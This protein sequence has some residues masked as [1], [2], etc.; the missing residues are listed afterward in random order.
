M[1]VYASTAGSTIVGVKCEKCSCEYFYELA[2][3]G[4]GRGTAPLGLA[5]GLARDAATQAAEGNLADR[6]ASEAELVPCPRCHWINDDLVRGY[7]RGRYRGLGKI[8]LYVA[9]AGAAISLVTGWV[10][11]NGPPKDRHHALYILYGG[12]SAMAAFLGGMMGLRAWLRGRIR[13]NRDFPRPPRLP[14][15]TPPAL[16]G[17]GASGKLFLADQANS[18]LPVSEWLEFQIGRVLFPL[19]CCQCLKTATKEHALVIPVSDQLVLEVPRCLAC[20]R[21]SASVS[22]IGW[23]LFVLIALLV[24]G[25]TITAIWSNASY[26]C[27]IM[28]GLV[29]LFLISVAVLVKFATPVALVESAV[30]DAARGVVKVRFPNEQY[31]RLIMSQDQDRDE[32][33]HLP[34]ETGDS[35][36]IQA[37]DIDIRRT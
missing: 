22:N 10:L 3:F 29:V 32:L 8:A 20:A 24:A 9:I 21:K 4:E 11:S 14:A 18:P 36:A 7:R 25:L 15:G 23:V 31:R 35:T 2:R 28:S 26:S 12:P 5:S 1:N 37:D 13:P 19:V 17:D 33:E 16:F 27:G 34:I 30:V 6:L